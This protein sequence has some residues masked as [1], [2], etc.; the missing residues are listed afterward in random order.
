[1]KKILFISI[2]LVV[3]LFYI[4]SS[5]TS[6]AL[7]TSGSCSGWNEDISCSSL[8]ETSCDATS[9]CFWSPA[10]D[11]GGI[12]EDGVCGGANTTY[13]YDATDYVM[14]GIPGIPYYCQSGV[15]SATPAF[16]SAGDSSN[17]VCLG[18]GVGE[19]SGTCIANRDPVP[20]IIPD[21]AVGTVMVTSKYTVGGGPAVASWN[22]TGEASM[23]VLN[24]SQSS[25]A[26]QPIGN[27]YVTP[28]AGP[29]NYVVDAVKNGTTTLPYNAGTGAW[30]PINLTDTS[31]AIFDI[32]WRVSAGIPT[33]TSTSTSTPTPVPATPVPPPATAP[34]PAPTTCGENASIPG[35]NLPSSIT[36]TPGETQSF[37][38]DINNAGET[39]WYN[40]NYF[41]F[42]KT[43]GTP[44]ISPTYGHLL[45]VI[46]PG[47]TPRWT[48]TLT[49]PA[50][51]GS[52]PF[53][54][55]M[56]HT[57]GAVYM[58]PN[59]TTCTAPAADS[60]FGSVWASTIVVSS[61]CQLGYG[62]A[63]TGATSSANICGQTNPGGAGT[64]QCDGSCSGA[65]GTTPPDS[66]CPDPTVDITADTSPINFSAS[67]IIRWVATNV[68]SCTVD[69]YDWTSSPQNTGTLYSDRTYTINCPGTYHSTATDSVTVAVYPELTCSPTNQTVYP[70][71]NAN[72]TT[73]GGDGNYSWTGGGTPASQMYS[74]LTTFATAYS[75]SGS[76]TVTVN[77]NDV[78]KTCAVS[79][80]NR[81]VSCNN[82]ASCSGPTVVLPNNGGGAGGVGGVTGASNDYCGTPSV[83][84]S[85]G[86][87]D[88]GTPPSPQSAY[89]VQIAKKTGGVYDW[90][91]RDTGKISVASLQKTYTVSMAE[92]DA[93][94]VILDFG[95]T[96]A[97]RVRVWNSADSVSSWS[98][99]SSDFTMASHPY[100]QVNLTSNKSKPAKNTIVTF[101]ATGTDI[102]SS[103]KSGTETI[104]F[105]DG[106]QSS[107][108]FYTGTFAHTYTTEGTMDV[109]FKVVDNQGYAC[110]LTK[111][112]M[113]SVQKEIPE[114]IEVAPR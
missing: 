103:P 45:S 36:M 73:S 88:Y 7:T 93:S 101:S 77:S 38:A 4:F 34:A 47:N 72:F 25:S 81:P 94:S 69:T 74:D 22:I 79:V 11:G 48:F 60:L 23:T 62:N 58:K 15:T 50:T 41:K 107:Q 98:T 40:G 10:G 29:T 49:A 95:G 82:P 109:T 28:T 43:A 56:V 9:G 102:F 108:A 110:T 31:I 26:D 33:P 16:P 100:P 71:Q 67:T 55:Q 42:I 52:Y 61:G 63:C 66:S 39:M 64:I 27:Y 21:P 2:L 96:Y 13:A 92:G 6:L 20:V 111:N 90:T 44:V 105:G 89:Q 5:G 78:N 35:T 54:M 53:A 86:Y 87:Y 114:W 113:I 85:W 70:D 112:Q 99:A 51:E 8:S 14:V 12:A 57:A 32:T 19:D 37:Y 17:W 18:Q 76:K 1:M 83:D 97:A 30:G 65:A 80:L 104:T 75:T 3:S 106:A 24:D 59:G 91:Y 46:N 84:V 68:S